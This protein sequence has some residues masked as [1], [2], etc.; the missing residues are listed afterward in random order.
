VCRLVDGDDPAHAGHPPA[1][2]RHGEREQ[3]HERGHDH[4]Q[5]VGEAMR[6]AQ[7]Q[8]GQVAAPGGGEQDDDDRRPHGPHA[9]LAV[10]RVG[11]AAGEPQ[12]PPGG[13]AVEDQAAHQRTA[14][15]DEAEGGEVRHHERRDVHGQDAD[16]RQDT[17][18]Q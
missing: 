11:V 2:E 15:D 12:Q 1:R 7:A 17:K 5:R 14:G 3:E 16:R 6:V 9:V 4:G 8:G 13:E 10:E 18:R